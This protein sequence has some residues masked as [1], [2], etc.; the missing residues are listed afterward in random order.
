MPDHPTPLD[1]GFDG[2]FE[3][4]AELLRSL[5]DEPVELAD[6][7]DGLWSR[8]AGAIDP[9]AETSAPSAGAEPVA[10]VVGID[11]RRRTT[12]RRWLF[13]TAAACVIAAAVV[14]GVVAAVRSDARPTELAAA[15]LSAYP[16]ARVGKAGGQV[17]LVRQDDRLRLRVD[18]HDLPSLPAG[19]FY[20]MWLL[21]PNGG[22]PVSV[23]TMKNSPSD[24]AT[25]VDLPAGTNTDRYHIVDVSVQEDNAGPEHS[26]NSVLRGTLVA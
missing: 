17:E 10:D 11:P 25:Y 15:D 1:D 26:G 24:V 22:A 2:E 4:E 16:G 9:D 6:A 7:P 18:M 13:A 14:I 23:A 8:I 5:A 12:R 3:R 21:D 19:T 20:E